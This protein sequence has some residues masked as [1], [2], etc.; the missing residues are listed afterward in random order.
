MEPG[1]E[2]E[3]EA[4]PTGSTSP[5]DPVRAVEPPADHD[6][7][8][9]FLKELPVLL[10][11]AFGLAFLL[12]TFV[13]QVFYIP[14][15]S[16]RPTLVEDDRIVVEKLSYRFGDPSRGDVVV[17]AGEDRFSTTVNE[18]GVQRV[19]RGVGQF[20]GV[21]P[22][23]ARDLVKRI[24]GLPG[25]VVELHDGVVSVNGVELDEPYAALDNDDGRWEVPEG[26]VFV[27]GDN[28]S[29]SADSRSSLGFVDMD[30]IVG[31]AIVKIWPFD[32]A[33]SIEGGGTISDG[34]VPAPGDDAGALPP[35]G[36]MAIPVIGFVAARPR[37]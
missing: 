35:L 20:L 8:I 31:R 5:A 4:A 13:L 25:D 28:R 2:G 32:R 14:S 19:I 29:N 7:F 30:D 3:Q 17:F 26:Q 12:R 9:T 15:A 10:L 1:D 16:M 24:I 37:D 18:S 27:M 6:S 22:V 11:V 21:V 23:D 34:S 33:G 36:A